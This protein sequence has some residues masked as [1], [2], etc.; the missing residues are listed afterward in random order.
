VRRAPICAL[1][2]VL[3][4]ALAAGCVAGH[5][6]TPPKVLEAAASDGPGHAGKAV[7]FTGRVFEADTH[8]GVARFLMAVDGAQLVAYC[9]WPLDGAAVAQGDPVIV[10][11]R[12]RD[13]VPNP[14]SLPGPTPDLAVDAVAVEVVGEAASGA[15]TDPAL[16]RRWTEGGVADTV[17]PR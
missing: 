5:Y 13:K 16:Y 10:L 1:G 9:E 7:A 12:V 15:S 8:G 4:A 11:G 2:A 6:L 3:L 17:P 14:L